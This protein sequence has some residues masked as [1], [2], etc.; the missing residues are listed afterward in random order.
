MRLILLCFMLVGLTHR[1]LPTKVENIEKLDLTV[2]GN[3]DIKDLTLDDVIEMTDDDN[4]LVIEGDSADS[5]DVPD[6]PAGYSVTQT[7]EGGYDVFTY[8]GS[9]GDPTVT[10]KIDQDV[11]HS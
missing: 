4:T 8:T 2:N 9:S 5:V 1:L 3:H 10:L 11:P 6:A 7:S